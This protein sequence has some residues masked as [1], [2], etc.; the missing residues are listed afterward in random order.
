MTNNKIVSI[1]YLR[2]IAALGVVVCHYGSNISSLLNFGQNGVFVFFL[3]SGFV[4]VY[5]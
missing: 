3:I 4:I 5:S 2:G 1:Q